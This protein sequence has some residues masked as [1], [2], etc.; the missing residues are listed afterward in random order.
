MESRI[1]HFVMLSYFD[2]V[3]WNICCHLHLPC[4][5]QHRWGGSGGRSLLTFLLF[6]LSNFRVI[7]SFGKE[8]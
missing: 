6:H 4:Y 8:V 7:L 5:H 3:L 2:G 1:S